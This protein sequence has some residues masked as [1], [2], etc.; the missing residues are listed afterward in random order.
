VY[1]V[2]RWKFS[3]VYSLG[4]GEGELLIT[5]LKLANLAATIANRGYYIAPHLV[6][7]I[8]KN[9]NPLPEYTEKHETGVA[10]PYFEE[11]IN[12]MEMA[13]LQGT[14]SRSAV[15]PGITMCGKT[16]TS[17]NKKGED[18]AIFIAFAPKYNPK[19]AI[20]VFVEN[21]G[22]GGFHSAPIASIL[23][24]KF[25]K[26]KVERQAYATEWMNKNYMWRVQVT[27]PVP[28]GAKPIQKD[29]SKRLIPK[30]IAS[31]KP[32]SES[33]SATGL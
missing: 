22:Y 2:K 24:E 23:I 31:L 5:P 27:N 3:N 10:R 25:L 7:G 4:I 29:T 17:Q 16:G 20:A 33:K 18:H 19:I 14:V 15:I 12:G 13:V 30:P 32:K 28:N 6:K 26:G 8:N 1:G 21:A 9:N 11:V